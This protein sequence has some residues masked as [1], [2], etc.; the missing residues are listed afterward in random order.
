MEI[1]FSS[2][3]FNDSFS[4]ALL[5]ASQNKERN[6]SNDFTLTNI[7]L[8]AFKIALNFKLFEFNAYP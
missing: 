1:F 5:S 3:V 7:E 8:G 6:T 4:N 2:T